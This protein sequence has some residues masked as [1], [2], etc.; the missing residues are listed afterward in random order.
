MN[1]NK[2]LINWNNSYKE[3]TR[4]LDFKFKIL[5]HCSQLIKKNHKIMVWN[6]I[7][8]VKV[9][10]KIWNLKVIPKIQISQNWKCY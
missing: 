4:L 2:L 6:R 10:I 3:K 5:N 7:K 9:L 8:K 1:N